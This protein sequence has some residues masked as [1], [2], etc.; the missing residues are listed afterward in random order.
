MVVNFTRLCN[1]NV[2]TIITCDYNSILQRTQLILL[3]YE[4]KINVRVVDEEI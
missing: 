2:V 1:I 3:R 4:N